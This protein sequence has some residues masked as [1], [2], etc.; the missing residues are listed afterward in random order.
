M[1]TFHGDRRSFRQGSNGD[2]KLTSPGLGGCWLILHIPWSMSYKW[3]TCNQSKQLKSSFS[4]YVESGVP[5]LQMSF[6]RN[7][8]WLSGR[9]NVWQ[10]AC[11]IWQRTALTVMLAT[12]FGI[13]I[14]IRQNPCPV[15]KWMAHP[16]LYGLE[17][18]QYPNFNDNK[19][20]LLYVL[21]LSLG[22]WRIFLLFFGNM[23]G[24]FDCELSQD[25]L[26]ERMR[27]S[28]KSTAHLP[29]GLVRFIPARSH[30]RRRGKIRSI[31][32]SRGDASTLLRGLTELG[33]LEKGG[34]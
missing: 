8:L 33:C 23:K 3:S 25:L 11:H 32:T 4:S 7:L 29:G 21:S 22:S 27:D 26:G 17:D 31:K 13:Y 30:H 6:I 20:Y 18:V 5:I 14:Y 34:C 28:T 9:R 19:V 12:C 16:C 15:W 1:S 10:R 24:R 2:R